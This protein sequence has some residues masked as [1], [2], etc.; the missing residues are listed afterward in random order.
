MKHVKVEIRWEDI[1]CEDDSSKVCIF[2]MDFDET[3]EENEVI[4]QGGPGSEVP[5][6]IQAVFS[7]MNLIGSSEAE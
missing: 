2:D 6:L 4:E 7:Y 1:L 3:L 5:I